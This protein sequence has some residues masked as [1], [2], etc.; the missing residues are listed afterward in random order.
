MIS[1]NTGGGPAQPLAGKP[2]LDIIQRALAAD[3]R[4]V[5]R[6]EPY[7]VRGYMPGPRPAHAMR[8]WVGAQKRRMLEL[9]G[10]RAGGWVCALRSTCRRTMSPSRRP[11]STRQRPRQAAA[12]L[13]FGA[14]ITLLDRSVPGGR[15]GDKRSGLPVG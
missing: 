3:G 10:R 4:V 2:V 1:P 5:S 11:A 15:P 6:G 13:R 14:F 12:H 7:D 8:V 9:I